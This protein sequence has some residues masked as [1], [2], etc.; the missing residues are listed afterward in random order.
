MKNYMFTHQRHSLYLTRDIQRKTGVSLFLYP[1]TDKTAFQGTVS[2]EGKK[3]I[4]T[5]KPNLSGA[6]CPLLCMKGKKNL[7]EKGEQTPRFLSPLI[8]VGQ[9]NFEPVK[10]QKKEKFSRF[11]RKYPF[12]NVPLDIRE[13]KFFD[14]ER[15]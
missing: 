14:G 1:D 3:I 13:Q 6:I 7:S 9:R 15:I 5:L 8:S 4:F 2:V 12:W 11:D 10:G